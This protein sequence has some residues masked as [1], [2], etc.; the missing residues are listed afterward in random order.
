MKL[1]VFRETGKTAVEESDELGHAVITVV[2]E[3][4]SSAKMSA[5]PAPKKIKPGYLVITR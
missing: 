2:Q 4:K 1:I 5:K 3:H